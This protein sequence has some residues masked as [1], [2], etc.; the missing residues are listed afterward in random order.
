M[1]SQVT[2]FP[3][4]I[5]LHKTSVHITQSKVRNPHL[6]TALPQYT[7][8]GMS[9]ESPLSNSHVDRVHNGSSQT[10][11]IHHARSISEIKAALSSLYTREATVTARLDSLLSSQKEFQRELGRL[12]ILRA[13]L[14]SQTNTTRSIS[15]NM[16]SDASATASMI[17]SAVKRL[18]LEQLRVK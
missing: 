17:S 3:A 16:L 18:D 9:P 7:S 12:D 10:P 14:S 6:S 4:A 15:N 13:H 8:D 1:R 11:D 5:S 2:S